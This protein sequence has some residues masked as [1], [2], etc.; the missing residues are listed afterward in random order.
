ML[1]N[2]PEDTTSF[3]GRTRELAD[4]AA[5]L[6]GSRL[7]TI[8]GSAGVGKSRLALHAVTALDEGAEDGVCWADLWPLQDESLLP[9]TV[10]DALDLS[11][12]TPRLP[13]EALCSWVGER[14]LLL[15]LDSCEHVLAD[16]AALVAE[17]L[18][19][20]PRLTVLATSREPFGLR[21]EHVIRLA[22]LRDADEAYALFADRA[23]AA[24]HPLTTGD[25]PTADH[26]CAQLE[27]VP[28]ALELAAAQLRHLPLAAVAQRDR[29]V[30]DVEAPS[31][32]SVPPRHGALRTAVGWS[33]ELCTPT[34]RLVWARLALLPAAFDAEAARATASAWPLND[35]DV[36]DAT[37]RLAEKSVLIGRDDGFRM[38]HT[39]REYG[40][41]WLDELG[42]RQAT[43]DRH[44]AH[45]LDVVA[46]ADAAWLT[47]EQAYWYDRVE[48]LY[49]HVRAALRHL[50]TRRPDDAVALT[51]LV[52]FFWVCCGHLHEGRHYLQQALA[53]TEKPGP[54]RT[55]ALWVW[56]LIH[57]LQGRYDE[58]RALS[59][60]C[61]EAALADG[62]PDEIR[63]AAYLQGLVELL[64]GR[65][66]TALA[67]A[68]EFL[69]PLPADA[70]PGAAHDPG[71]D[72]TLS[73][74]GE[75]LC[76]L[77]RVFA[78]TGAGHL[79]QARSHAEDLRAR[80]VALGE[81]WTRSYVDYQLALIAL[82]Q[83]RATAAVAH[84]RA[85]LDAKR[86]IGDRFGIAMGLDLLSVACAEQG[87]GESSARACGAGHQFWEAVG[88]PQ[89]G[90]PEVAPLRE[91]GE[92]TARALIGEEPYEAAFREGV[93]G[94]PHRLL[95]WAAEARPWPDA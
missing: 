9:A 69:P 62:A 95:V 52:G 6:S 29:S 19:A 11:D 91:R 50:M 89:R 68:Q 43:A 65:P 2:I 48:A 72:L 38:L 81:Y 67:V 92:A 64:D 32:E 94:S 7:V 90:T 60:T 16:C 73:S 70:P 5:A 55:R 30:L 49:P 53:L 42:E 15:V 34:E 37:H 51:G 87:D 28:L 23:E 82:F 56:A 18:T 58:G 75:A 20:C 25:R 57:I 24:G 35:A 93:E 86:R 36:I 14:D 74:P 8:V 22:P 79:V 31:R 84:A 77:V 33:H 54:A 78:L 71:P 13:M 1:K 83:E 45:V 21:G 76:A 47:P 10:A 3:V 46:R 39:I 88:H 85:T 4:I 26:L 27:G 12:H 44:A 66:L 40:L 59:E 80:C 41:M 63:R 17:L 61:R